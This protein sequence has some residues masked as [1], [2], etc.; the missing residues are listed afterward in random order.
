MSI[1]LSYSTCLGRVRDL[2]TSSRFGVQDKFDLQDGLL[3][4]F[5][6]SI[7]SKSSFF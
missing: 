7:N 2:K 4:T 5:K 1:Y 6:D 3:D